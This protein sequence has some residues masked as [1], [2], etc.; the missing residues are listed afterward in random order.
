MHAEGGD[1]LGCEELGHAGRLRGPKDGLLHGRV[2]QR[3]QARQRLRDGRAV[4]LAEDRAGGVALEA[5]VGQKGHPLQGLERGGVRDEVGA[6][7]ED[8]QPGEARAQRGPRRRQAVAPR[9]ELR[10]LGE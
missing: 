1:A 8:L 10:E 6:Q 2:V 5:E 9:E 4:A 7:V 3:L